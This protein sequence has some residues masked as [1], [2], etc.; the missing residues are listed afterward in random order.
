MLSCDCLLI[1]ESRYMLQWIKSNWYYIRV[2][3]TVICVAALAFFVPWHE[4]FLLIR[5]MDLLWLLL[6]LVIQFCLGAFDSIRVQILLRLKPI[7]RLPNLVLTLKTSLVAQLPTGVLGGEVYRGAK[8]REFGVDISYAAGALIICRVLSV[9]SLFLIGGMVAA[10]LLVSGGGIARVYGQA[11]L[12]MA[13]IVGFGLGFFLLVL[14]FFGRRALP[15]VPTQYL[16]AKLSPLST[17]V[18]HSLGFVTFFSLMIV[19]LRTF[20]LLALLLALNLNVG[21]VI[22][23][24]AIVAGSLLSMFPITLAA[25]GLR[26]GGIAG[27]LI[28]HGI[29][30]S[31]AFSLAVLLR[32]CAILASFINI[33]WLIG[34]LKLRERRR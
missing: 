12:F 11:F 5:N 21:F 18:F 8:M 14:L 32:V 6:I 24:I 17:I 15:W 19:I 4:G 9:A 25:I 29:E 31:T 30:P 33:A 23:L 10:C 26:E 20:T 13:C 1:V 34:V 28:F 3:F 7:Y 22:A 16:K 2:V 27:I